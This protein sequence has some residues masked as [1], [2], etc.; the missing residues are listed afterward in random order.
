MFHWWGNYRHP[1]FC[2]IYFTR[3]GWDCKWVAPTLHFAGIVE[4]SVGLIHIA[5]LM[6]LVYSSKSFY[7]YSRYACICGMSIFLAFEIFDVIVGD[8]MELLEHWTYT[9]AYIV[10]MIL[11]ECEAHFHRHMPDIYS[12]VERQDGYELGSK[13]KPLEN[14]VKSSDTQLNW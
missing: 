8:R 7:K 12:M 9:V 14:D 1:K 4:V 3:M 13:K 11:L 2:N 6:C 5:V 10:T